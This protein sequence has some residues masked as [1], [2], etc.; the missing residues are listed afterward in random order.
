MPLAFIVRGVREGENLLPQL[1]LKGRV[2]GQLG[3]VVRR[4]IEPLV[5]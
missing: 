3:R 2:E 5:A 1:R 4:A